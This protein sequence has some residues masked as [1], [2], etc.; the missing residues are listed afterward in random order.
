MKMEQRSI[1]PW[2]DIDGPKNAF[3]FDRREVIDPWDWWAG[4]HH[5]SVGT[6]CSFFVHSVARLST[7]HGDHDHS[8]MLPLLASQQSYVRP[9]AA[10]GL[11][12]EVDDRSP[13]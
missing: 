11:K 3:D 2:V 5:G 7:T 10:I 8:P 4:E 13:V 12:A 9:N 1:A 6:F